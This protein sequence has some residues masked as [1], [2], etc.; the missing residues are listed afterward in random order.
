MRKRCGYL[1]DQCLCDVGKQFGRE[2][3]IL[4]LINMEH[5]NNEEFFQK[6]NKIFDDEINGLNKYSSDSF[7]DQ[8]FK[9]IKVFIIYPFNL[10]ALVLSS[11]NYH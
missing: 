2:Q 11:E 8:S 3:T 7:Y 9:K 1:L 6:A 5:L 10:K 4:A